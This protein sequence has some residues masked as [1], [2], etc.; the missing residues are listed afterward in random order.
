MALKSDFPLIHV[1]TSE[2]SLLVMS[3]TWSQLFYHLDK[4]IALSVTLMYLLYS[5]SF[6][7]SYTIISNFCKPQQICLLTSFCI[8][9]LLTFPWLS[10]CSQVYCY[11]FKEFVKM[12]V[13]FVKI[14]IHNVLKHTC[15]WNNSNMSN[16]FTRVPEK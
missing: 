12:R 16:I 9:R 8:P 6:S 10:W 11:P 4:V 5:C 13:M 14:F 3:F 7:H 1:S 2:L 15:S